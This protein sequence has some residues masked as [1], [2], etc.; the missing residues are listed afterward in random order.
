MLA[1]SRGSVE[2]EDFT[3]IVVRASADQYPE[4]RQPRWNNPVG[5][6]NGDQRHKVRLWGSYDLPV[7]REAGALTLGLMQRYDSGRPY[8]YSMSVDTRPYVTNPGYLIPPSTVTYFVSPRG[9][10]RFDGAFRTDASLSWNRHVR[11]PKLPSAQIFVRAVVYNV[12]NNLRVTSF[13]TTI[14]SRTGDSTLAAFNPFT[15]APVQGVNWKTGPS[16]G[17]PVSPGSYQSPRE[18]N[19]SAG[20][21]F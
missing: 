17:Q 5:Y 13:N 3:N 15:T 12:F 7:W 14:I 18:F 1:Y 9:A 20:F 8:D 4:Y 21:R 19:F 11:I 10:Y 2:A 6:L 16:F